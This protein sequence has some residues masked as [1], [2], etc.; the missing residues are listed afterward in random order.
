MSKNSVVLDAILSTLNKQ[1]RLAVEFDPSAALQVIAGPGTGKTRVLTAR[2]A[3]LLLK[4]GFQPR[5]II[6]T[7]FTNKAA[8]EMI[9]RLGV[10]LEGTDVKVEDL[11]IGTFHSI[12]LKILARFGSKIGLEPGW[13]IVEE[14]EINSII[15]DLIEKMPD[16]IRDYALSFNRVVNL[17]RPKNGGDTWVVHPKQVK[18]EIS[19]LKSHAVLPEEYEQEPEHDVAVV[20]FYYRYQAALRA[21]NALDFDDLL[22]FTFRLLCK[23]RCLPYVQ[24]V[25]VAEFQDTSGLQI[26][27]MFLFARGRHHLSRGITVVGDPDQSIYAFRNAHSQNFSSMAAKCPI[28]CSQ[29]VLIE[30]YRSS[31]KI[32]DTSETLMKQQL[33][34][35]HPRLP[36]RAQFDCD[37]PPV[38]INFPVGFLQGVS[39]AKELLYLKSLPDLFSYDDFAILVRQRRQIKSI[40]QAL[41][42]HRIPYR[43]IR[44]R[45]F[46]ELKEIT[47]MLNLLRCV[48]SEND[49]NA[50]IDCLLYPNKGFGQIS[51]ERLREVVD[52][53]R[54][55]NHDITAFSIVERVAEQRIPINITPKARLIVKDF[56]NMIHEVREIGDP[57]EFSTSSQTFTM[58][59]SEIF[60]KLYSLS[61]LEYEYLYKESGKSS[62]G[63]NNTK[64]KAKK[65]YSDRGEREG[66][67]E[68]EKREEGNDHNDDDGYEEKR[69]KDSAVGDTGNKK[70]GTAGQEPAHSDPRHKNIEILKE[71]FLDTKKLDNGPQT[72][73][74]PQTPSHFPAEEGGTCDLHEHLRKFFNSLSLYT[75]DTPQSDA[76]A[77]ESQNPH[78][79]AKQGAVTI[80]TIHGAKGLEWPVVFVPGCVEGIIPSIFPSGHKDEVSEDDDDDDDDKGKGSEDDLKMALETGT[81]SKDDR[82][83]SSK[84]PARLLDE[85]RRMFFVAQTR[86]K[87]LLYLSSVKEDNN[88]IYGG[89]SRFLTREVLDT[90]CDKQMALDSVESIRTL[91]EVMNKTIPSDAGNVFSFK[92]LVSDYKEFVQNRRESMVW[93]RRFIRNLLML[94]IT[95]N[96]V[97]SPTSN[98]GLTTDFSTAAE[99]LRIATQGKGLPMERTGST[100]SVRRKQRQF[101]SQPIKTTSQGTSKIRSQPQLSLEKSYA[102]KSNIKVSPAVKRTYAPKADSVR[103]SPTKGINISNNQNRASSNN[104]PD[105]T[106]FQ[107]ETKTGNI[108]PGMYPILRRTITTTP[109]NLDPSPPPKE[110]AKAKR[111]L[112]LKLEETTAAEVLFDANDLT[113][114]N[115]PIITNAK[116]LAKAIKRSSERSGENVGE[117]RQTPTNPSVKREALATERQIDIFSQLARAKKK[118]KLN[119]SAIIVIDD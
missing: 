30:N 97:P 114:D 13:R 81:S 51:A 22:M 87:V 69:I 49:T 79:T 14:R 59:L 45:A 40:E 89:P 5:D 1:Q 103:I 67:G 31:Q 39:L 42:D 64:K 118:A 20:Y 3:Y 61:G 82:G 111:N 28:P 6:V 66:G 19:K 34:D 53:R 16:P 50:I 44:G 102:P 2:V 99:Q 96:R 70:S 83:K 94:D 93:N 116:T 98:L 26:D 24:H 85:E 12:C 78:E 73:T 71:Y 9:E 105:N 35:R 60:D 43:I 36:L 80:S 77:F 110:L 106:N 46:W 74:Q 25:F 18:N 56:V 100:V 62:Q 33:K 95:K 68:E 11:F 104:I 117:A 65:K 91:Y 92:R 88:P 52:I 32:L 109:I 72:Q 41:I 37:F 115:R 21:L 119:K 8:R 10:L 58:S 75:S 101:Q 107:T 17:C 113:V 23:E 57:M 76:D 7:T 15:D 29:V 48:Y 63:N 90:V 38:Y 27:L 84:N 55:K 86:A 108:S 54:A 112:K 4:C 47:A